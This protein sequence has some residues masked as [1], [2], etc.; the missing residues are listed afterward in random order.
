[1]RTLEVTTWLADYLASNWPGCAQ[2]Y[3]LER[4]R[5]RGRKI[6]RETVFGITSLP[7]ERAGA[8]ELSKLIRAHWG[9]ENGLHNRRDV[10]LREDASRIRR[11]GASQVMAA[12]RNL[13]IYLRPRS[14]RPTLAAAIRYH[15]CHPQ[16][17]LE[18]LSTRA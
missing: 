6:E 1:M 15:M 3:R 9:I 12:L 17:S 5:R 10:T 13:I 18:L 4:E 16:K 2:V 7:R 14:G 11:G 8:A